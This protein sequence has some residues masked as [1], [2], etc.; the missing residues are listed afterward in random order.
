MGQAPS[1]QLEITVRVV[2]ERRVVGAPERDAG[3]V[4]LEH[5]HGRSTAWSQNPSP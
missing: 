2:P 1:V 5:D 4:A 3:V